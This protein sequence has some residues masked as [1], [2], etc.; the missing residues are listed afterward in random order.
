MKITKELLNK[1]SKGLCTEEERKVV[2]AWF[3]MDEGPA[4]GL[5]MYIGD[6]VNKER[7][8]SRVSQNIP[9]FG[10][11]SG[12]Q[13]IPL[14]RRVARYV[15]V[16][17][18]IFAAFLGGRF[19]AS[20]ANANNIVDKSPKDLLYVYGENGSY[21]QIEGEKYDV[22]FDGKLKLFNGSDKPKVITC[23]TKEFQMEP[24]QTYL[25]DGSYHDPKMISKDFDDQ[26]F[27]HLK[28][29]FSIKIIRDQQ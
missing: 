14:Y 4:T 17:C 20:S 24:F 10:N 27:N 25:L 2:E 23:G 22:K 3:E 6:E 1:H 12:S 28:G 19:S 16:A 29:D 7:I 5:R 18:I 9:L 13:T 11:Q 26:Y 8:W 15:A 21:A